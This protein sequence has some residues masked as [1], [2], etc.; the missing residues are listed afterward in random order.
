MVYKIWACRRIVAVL[1]IGLCCISWLQAPGHILRCASVK[2]QVHLV[3]RHT[4]TIC[5]SSACMSKRDFRTCVRSFVFQGAATCKSLATLGLSTFHNWRGGARL[6]WE[7]CQLIKVSEDHHHIHHEWQWVAAIRVLHC[8]LHELLNSMCKNQIYR[9]NLS[10]T[11]SHQLDTN[12]C[13]EFLSEFLDARR[14]IRRRRRTWSWHWVVE[15]KIFIANSECRWSE[16][17]LN[18]YTASSYRLRL[19]KSMS[20]GSIRLQEGKPPWSKTCEHCFD[21]YGNYRLHALHIC[22]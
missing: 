9:L 8:P 15:F 3:V 7:D 10:T 2:C 12:P 14:R 13:L 1:S 22:K 20:W 4:S 11:S 6:L 21:G 19:D 5:C 18:L 17:Q 16:L